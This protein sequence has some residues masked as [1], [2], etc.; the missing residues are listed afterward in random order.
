MEC[1]Y[2]GKELEYHDWYYTGHYSSGNYQ[3]MGDIYKC[4]NNE[5]FEDLE[6][7]KEYVKENNLTIGENGDFGTLEE[8]CCE[9]GYHNGFFYTDANDDLEEGYPC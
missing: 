7:A 6:D 9:S 5:W 1:P 8:V 3:K 4:P 2:C